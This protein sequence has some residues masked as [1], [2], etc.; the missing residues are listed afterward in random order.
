VGR[1]VDWRRTRANFLVDLDDEGF[2]EHAWL[3]RVL[4]FGDVELRVRDLMPRC[5]MVNAAQGGLP[6]DGGL[7]KSITDLSEGALGVVADVIEG[8]SVQVGAPVSLS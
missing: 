5:V 7:L 6:V 1:P 8:G 4:R 2:P 3:G